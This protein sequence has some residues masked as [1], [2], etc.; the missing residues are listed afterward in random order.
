MQRIS[1]FGLFDLDFTLV[2]GLVPGKPEDLLLWDVRK[3][4]P[5]KGHLDQGFRADGRSVS[6]PRFMP[7]PNLPPLLLYDLGS[8]PAGVDPQQVI[9]IDWLRERLPE[10]PSVTREKL[11]RQYGMLPEH[12]VALLVGTKQSSEPGPA[13]RDAWGGGGGTSG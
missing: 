5:V 11:V 2:Q 7:E 8:L 1:G 6:P 10:L 12:S 9:N 4:L 3:Y 13:A